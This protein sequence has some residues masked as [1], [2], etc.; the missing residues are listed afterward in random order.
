[1]SFVRTL[2]TLAV[3]FAAA[4]GMQKVRDMGGMEA[5]R[6]KM[7]GAGQPGGMADEIGTMAQKMGLPVQTRAIARYV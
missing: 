4:K 1:M 3:G 2:A 7:R 6:T 5:L